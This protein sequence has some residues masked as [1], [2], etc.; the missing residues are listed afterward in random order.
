MLNAPVYIL[1]DTAIMTFVHHPATG[2]LLQQD[3]STSAP[4]GRAGEEGGPGERQGKPQ[5]QIQRHVS[6]AFFRL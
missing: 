1:Q 5:G 6:K 3:G 4:K 2:G